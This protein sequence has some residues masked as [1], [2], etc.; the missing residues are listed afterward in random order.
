MLLCSLLIYDRNV[1]NGRGAMALSSVLAPISGM[2]AG[3]APRWMWRGLFCIIEMG[4]GKME[5][6]GRGGGGKM[7][8][9]AVGEH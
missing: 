4:E 2:L 5:R 1:G 6:A 3:Y 8:F 7:G 9:A